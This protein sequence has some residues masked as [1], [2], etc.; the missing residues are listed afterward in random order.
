MAIGLG[1]GREAAQEL[2]VW[3]AIAL[4]R[5]ADEK[6]DV[7][8]P[9]LWP[10]HRF[11]QGN[12]GT[13]P[14]GLL[15]IADQAVGLARRLRGGDEVVVGGQEHHAADVVIHDQIVDWR[16]GGGLA[17]GECDQE[18]LAD[19]LFWGHAVQ[20]FLNAGGGGLG[21]GARCGVHAARGDERGYEHEEYQEEDGETPHFQPS[22]P[23]RF[24]IRAWTS[25][26]MLPPETTITAGRAVTLPARTAASPTAP[27]PSI[28]SP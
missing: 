4:L 6:R 17:A 7:S 3:I 26:W 8:P 24:T 27:A 20:E 2:V 1:G 5:D 10:G 9:P 21:L 18:Q 23:R 14:F 19:S 12:E 15:Q 25:G 16:F 28:F 11:V 13:I 22:S